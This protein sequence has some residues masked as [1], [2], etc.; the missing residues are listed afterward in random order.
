MWRRSLRTRTSK[1]S[2]DEDKLEKESEDEDKLEKESEDIKVDKKSKQG[3]SNKSLELT[4]FVTFS[5]SPFPYPFPFLVACPPPPP[6]L[7]LRHAPVRVFCGV[8]CPPPSPSPPDH[9]IS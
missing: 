2:E 4:Q 8:L 3:C 9:E 1:E 6:L 5:R 7:P